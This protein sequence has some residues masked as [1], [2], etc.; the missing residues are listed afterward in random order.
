M[1]I[2]KT[3]SLLLFLCHAHTEKY[4]KK[5][6]LN[7]LVHV[8]FHVAQKKRRRRRGIRSKQVRKSNNWEGK[9]DQPSFVVLS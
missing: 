7:T 2:Y 5:S 4:R 8:F 3:F 6:F 9:R 1:C